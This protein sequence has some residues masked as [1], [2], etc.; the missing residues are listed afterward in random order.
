MV[1]IHSQPVGF[2]GVTREACSDGSK[3]ILIYASEK[4]MDETLDPLSDAL[5]TFVKFDNRYF[6][7]EVSAAATEEHSNAM[8]EMS[9]TSTLRG[10]GIKK[11]RSDSMDS[12][13]TNQ[14]SMGDFDDEIRNATF[15][16]SG[17]V[18]AGGSSKETFDYGNQ[19]D[20]LV[21][22]SL[23]EAPPAGSPEELAP[24]DEFHEM[25]ERNSTSFISGADLA[26][27]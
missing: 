17:D 15:D 18:F 9:Y 4:A 21:D 13:A 7:Q 2:A 25:Q 27:T 22:V 6:K 8:K 16:E 14:A 26:R 3:P 23:D 12:M 19:T 10:A 1:L 20:D 11:A 24:V 5:K